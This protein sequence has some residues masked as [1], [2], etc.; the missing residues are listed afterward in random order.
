M[1]L[2]DLKE[3]TWE[4]PQTAEQ[5]RDVANLF[6]QPLPARDAASKLY[7]LIGDD[8]LYDQ[9]EYTKKKDGPNADV[10]WVV[11][12]KLD[13]WIRGGKASGKGSDYRDQN[14]NWRDPWD[15]EAIGILKRLVKRYSK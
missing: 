8:D 7:N 10:R 6:R 14:A 13:D 2:K 3:G 4:A 1:K 5:A 15:P 12:S 11:A 9:I